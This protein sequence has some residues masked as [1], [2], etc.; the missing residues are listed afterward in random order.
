MSG[1]ES[2]RVDLGEI[3]SAEI[4]VNGDEMEEEQ[5]VISQACNYMKQFCESISKAGNARLSAKSKL[6][7]REMQERM[8]SLQLGMHEEI[9]GE[10]DEL[11]GGQIHSTPKNAQTNSNKKNDQADRGKEQNGVKPKQKK[12][13]TKIASEKVEKEE[14][15]SDNGSDESS[16]S[17]KSSTAAD[18]SSMS[19]DEVSERMKRLKSK[20]SRDV[21]LEKLLERIDNRRAPEIGNFDPNT[22]ETLAEYLSRFEKY[23]KD[24]L[25][26]DSTY[27][28]PELEKH[29]SGKTLKALQ[30]LKDKKDTYKKLKKKLAKWDEDT[31]ELRKKRAREKFQAMKFTAKE[32]LYLYCNRLETQF[33]LAYP[34]HKVEKSSLLR[35]KLTET[36]S[37][38]FRKAINEHVLRNHMEEKK[39]TWSS[40]KKLASLKDGQNK[41][42]DISSEDD[43]KEIVINIQ[44]NKPE[45]VR[46]AYYETPHGNYDQASRPRI[47]YPPRF[48]QNTDRFNDN[49]NWQDNRRM[50]SPNQNYQNHNRYQQKQISGTQESNFRRPPEMKSCS[51][52]YKLGHTRENCRT[53]LRQCH[54]CSKPGHFS[55]EC[56]YNQSNNNHMRSRSQPPRHED[57]SRNR[58]REN[59]Y[60]FR[61]SDHHNADSNQQAETNRESRKDTNV[62]DRNRSTNC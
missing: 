62:P 37:K 39:T 53:L 52:C 46:N 20:K 23:C 31:V 28:I 45:T 12:V 49:L 36:V 6:Q 14:T 40:I 19:S 21:V 43:E 60:Q 25:K 38:N 24:N 26:G 27:W 2:D 7:I 57:Q 51:F 5:E 17:E 3:I 61:N 22:G 15:D 18:E 9:K 16:V 29:L 1:E 56:T 35:D 44:Q 10:D 42:I 50:I 41:T 11:K 33:K 59:R 32:D 58:F 30:S 13:P 4:E 48:N 55:R 8:S 54:T 47:P 34:K